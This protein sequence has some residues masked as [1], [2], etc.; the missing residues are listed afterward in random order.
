MML[1]VCVCVRVCV[2]RKISHSR[3]VFALRA[4][5]CVRVCVWRKISHSRVVFALRACVC[6]CACVCVY[7]CECIRD[8]MVQW[9]H[10]FYVSQLLHTNRHNRH[11]LTHTNRH[12][13]L[14]TQ[15]YK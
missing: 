12:T 7:V 9:A 1:C 6:V 4:W 14:H 5:C 15:A 3:V 13:G 8:A 2:S 10:G 11:M